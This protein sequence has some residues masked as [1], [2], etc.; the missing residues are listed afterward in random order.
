MASLICYFF[1]H[2]PS[3]QWELWW[4]RRCKHTFHYVPRR[5]K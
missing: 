2:R 4:C 1:G 3:N 5:R